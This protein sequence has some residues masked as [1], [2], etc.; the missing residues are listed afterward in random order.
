MKMLEHSSV[1]NLEWVIVAIV[2]THSGPIV[3]F[4]GDSITMETHSRSCSVDQLQTVTK[5]T[6]EEVG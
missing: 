1:L 2:K 4:L 6:I 5:S 3:S